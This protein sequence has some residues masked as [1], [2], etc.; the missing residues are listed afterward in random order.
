MGSKNIYSEIFHIVNIRNCID[1]EATKNKQEY[2]LKLDIQLSN[3]GRKQP[4]L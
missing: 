1:L 3:K 4:L 2:L